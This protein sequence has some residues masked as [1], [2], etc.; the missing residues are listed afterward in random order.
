MD[1]KPMGKKP[2]EW[3]RKRWMGKVVEDFKKVGI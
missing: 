3:P 1:W 2:R